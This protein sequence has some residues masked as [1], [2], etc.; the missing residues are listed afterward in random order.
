MARQKRLSD[1]QAELDVIDRQL[2]AA[3]GE[4]AHA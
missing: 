4:E 1:L 3:Q 2:A